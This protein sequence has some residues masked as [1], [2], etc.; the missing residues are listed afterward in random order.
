M[1]TGITFSDYPDDIANALRRANAYYYRFVES[2]TLHI[3]SRNFEAP[4]T[5]E[6]KE[7]IK[8]YLEFR[9]FPITVM[10]DN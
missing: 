8:T 9:G 7:R 5:D 6:E 10:F 3:V 1:I 4:L 2:T